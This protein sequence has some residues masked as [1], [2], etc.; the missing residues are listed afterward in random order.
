M[1]GCDALPRETPFASDVLISLQPEDGAG[2]RKVTFN[3]VATGESLEISKI[4]PTD[5]REGPFELLTVVDMLTDHRDA[6]V[7]GIA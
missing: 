1:L 4:L 2:N 6:Q 7:E 3:S 5:Q